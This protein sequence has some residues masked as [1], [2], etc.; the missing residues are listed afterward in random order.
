LSPKTK[1]LEINNGVATCLISTNKWTTHRTFY[2][3]EDALLFV[4]NRKWYVNDRG[5]GKLYLRSTY[6]RPIDL[7][8]AVFGAIQKDQIVD[9]IEEDK[10]WD[11]TSANLR[12]VDFTQN[13][14]NCKQHRDS[15]KAYKGVWINCRGKY[16][17]KLQVPYTTK[18]VYGPSRETQEE[19]AADYDLLAL[20]Y[21]G[22]YAKLNFT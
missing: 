21:H 7:H 14:L 6:P 12:I 11:C 9:H 13:S 3:D 18:R 4:I 16:Q 17:A 1:V 5:Y 8:R 15:T 2:V 10:W 20:E 22:K 19:A